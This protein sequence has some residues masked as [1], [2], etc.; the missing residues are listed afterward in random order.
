MLLI[1]LVGHITSFNFQTQNGDPYSIKEALLY[2]VPVIITPLP[3]ISEYGLE[4][5][6]NCYILNFDC[7][8][9]NDIAK[10]ITNIPKNKVKLPNDIYGKLLAPGKSTYQQ[11]LESRWIVEAT[12]KYFA[13]RT[14]DNELCV[15][16]N[17]DRYIPE[18]GERWETT[19]ARKE[20][21][22]HSGFVNVI[23]EIK[24]QGGTS[25]TTN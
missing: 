22:Y 13:T 21:L 17:K 18:A 20:L 19:Y 25:C 23:K 1:G 24:E 11:Q 3:F 6:K 12:N 2:N 8:N 5:G 9:V 4:H 10:S 14:S 7:S 16:H 15:I